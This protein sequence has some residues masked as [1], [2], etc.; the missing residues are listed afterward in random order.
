MPGQVAAAEA[1]KFWRPTNSSGFPRST[2]KRLPRDV[3]SQE[4]HQPNL[5]PK[6]RYRLFSCLAANCVSERKVDLKGMVLNA[7]KLLVQIFQAVQQEV[8]TCS[9][10][11]ATK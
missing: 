1:D 9:K 8:V 4:I 5:P 6:A 2:I 3:P 11:R 7:A 10:K